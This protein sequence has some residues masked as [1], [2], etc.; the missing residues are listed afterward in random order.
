MSTCAA[1]GA[2]MLIGWIAQSRRHRIAALESE[3]AEAALRAAA[4]ERLRIA[5]ELHDVVAHSLGVIAVQAGVGMHVID[6]DPAEATHV[7]RAHL[8][9]QPLEPGRDPPPA[10]RGAQ[11]TR[12]PPP[13]PRAR[14]RRPGP[15]RADDGGRRGLAVDLDVEGDTDDVPPGVEL[16]AYRI[17][18]EALTN[19]LQARP[20]QRGRP[21]ALNDRP[22]ALSGSR[23]PTTAAAPNGTRPAAATGWSGMRERV[24]RLRRLARRRA[25]APAAAS[26]S[27]PGCPTTE[28]RTD[29]P[30]RGRRR[31]GARAQRLRGAARA[32]PTTSR[33]SAR[34]PT[35][36]RR[37]DLV[38]R[39]RPDVVLMDIRMPEMDGLE[40]TRRITVDERLGDAGADPHHVRPRRV[41][42][43][44]AAGRRERLPAQGHPARRAAGR[45]PRGRRR[46]GAAG[47][48]RHPTPDRGVRARPDRRRRRA[49]PPGSTR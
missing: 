37:S 49:R 21:C 18:Q 1:Y 5:H 10:R 29:D 33:S 2:A 15:P 16:A 43:R 7:P 44:R 38:A 27:P 20:G 17:V 31:P 14:A 35:A 4:D 42:V 11:P 41:R 9:D 40:A 13:T 6:A 46:R 39:E 36:P 12:A 24:G 3:Q 26:G 25:R 47:A 8:P 22:R 30:G 19:V 32:R 28:D 23:S 34:P 48:Q 45:G